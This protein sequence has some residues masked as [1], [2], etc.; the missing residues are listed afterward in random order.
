MR[1]HA[2]FAASLLT[3]VAACGGSAEEPPVEQIVV[4]EPGEPASNATIAANSDGAEGSAVDLVAK[5]QAA[6]A[7]CSGC[8][9]AEAGEAS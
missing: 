3:F 6:F 2:I 7:V 5:G 1:K 4:R 8:H 9:V